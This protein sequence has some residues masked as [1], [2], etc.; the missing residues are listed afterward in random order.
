MASQGCCNKLAQ[1]K[2][3]E[4]AET[5][6]LTVMAARHPKS[7]CWQGCVPSKGSKRENFLAFSCFWW[8]WA[9][10]GF[11]PPYSSLCLLCPWVSMC[12][13]L[14]PFSF[15][16]FLLGLHPRHM[17]VPRLGVESELH[18]WAY[19]ITTAT[20]DPSHI[21]NL[22]HSSWQCRILNP[23]KPGIKPTSSWILVW[24]ITCWPSP[25][26]CKN[27]SHWI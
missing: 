12:A 10:L 3:L 1:T 8:P 22:C 20:W 13:L 4:T 9:F 16:C 21:C 24:F 7:R 2:Q 14:S 11:W 26:L 23:L 27:T 18:L 17:E 15:F 25:F 6:S 5:F 19:T